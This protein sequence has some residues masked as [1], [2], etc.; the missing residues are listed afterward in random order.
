MKNNMEEIPSEIFDW[1]QAHTFEE[2]D[3]TQQDI[4]LPYFSKEEY[5]EFYTIHREAK[6]TETLS[7][8]KERVAKILGRHF[9]EK[10]NAGNVHKGLLNRQIVFW[11][12]AAVFV[13][14]I[15]IISY[16]YIMKKPGEVI[17]KW[18]ALTDTIY[19]TKEVQSS[20]EKI[21]DTVYIY[22]TT[23]EKSINR[24]KENHYDI[25]DG[26]MVQ[27][28]ENED[29]EVLPV[30]ELENELNGPKKNSR[31]DDSLS[32]AYSIITL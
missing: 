21:H 26:K 30:S 15:T 1:M 3:K 17:S 4:I 14:F 10:H 27:G 19:V 24:K 20:P 2:L 6:I 32:K 28:E 12:A 5:N 18:S 7:P 29:I 16:A 22:K 9:D 31:K 8:G 13:F 25:T 23:E 11:K